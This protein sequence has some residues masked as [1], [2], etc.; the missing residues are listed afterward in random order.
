MTKVETRRRH[1]R[2]CLGAA[3]VLALVAT[4]VQPSAR[5]KAEALDCGS[6]LPPVPLPWH[7]PLPPAFNGV[8][9]DLRWEELP[10]APADAWAGQAH[11]QALFLHN[12]HLAFLEATAFAGLPRLQVLVITDFGKS[13][14][15]DL[16]TTVLPSDLFR[17]L[18]CLREL[19]LSDTSLTALPPDLFA[20]NPQLERL[21][22]TSNALTTLPSDLFAHN[23]RLKF[24]N[25][26]GNALTALPP[27][28]FAHNPR[29]GEY[30]GLFRN[31]LTTLPSDLFAH[32]PQL[33]F[34]SLDDNQLTALPPDLFA[35]N[36]QLTTLGLDDNQLTALPPDLFAHNSQLTTLVLSNNPLTTLPPNLFR[37]LTN[38]QHLRLWRNQLT[39]LPF[40]LFTGL[41]RLQTLVLSRNRLGNLAPAFLQALGLTQVRD[42]ALGSEAAGLYWQTRPRGDR[43]PAESNLPQATFDRYVAVIPYLE[44]LTLSADAPLTYPVCSVVPAAVPVRPRRARFVPG[45]DHPRV[46]LPLIAETVPPGDPRAAWHWERCADP[47]GRRCRDLA[48]GARAA[49]VPGPDDA[50]RY[51][52]ASFPALDPAGAWSPLRTPLVGPVNPVRCPARP[53]PTPFYG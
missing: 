10:A 36:P 19:H 14:D 51:L 4:A 1:G 11:L 12:S 6:S 41:P 47:Q 27:D 30:L 52:R 50:G 22:L 53:A 17:S 34:L 44:S 31:Q 28:L 18:P 32:N 8:T 35:H 45:A 33:K 21:F 26:N 3:L 2:V 49:Y 9:W 48:P 15:S 7:T 16:V 46:G 43:D 25:L 20:H 42:L 38:L 37:S 23:P 13:R 39:C 29:L 40:A 5:I 24:L